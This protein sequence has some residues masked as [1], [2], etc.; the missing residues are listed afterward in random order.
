M[1]QHQTNSEIIHHRCSAN[2]L[3]HKGAAKSITALWVCPSKASHGPGGAAPRVESRT[4]RVG[5][6]AMNA[7]NAGS[8][9]ARTPIASRMACRFCCVLGH[10]SNRCSES[11]TGTPHGHW[12]ECRG[13]HLRSCVADCICP[14]RNLRITFLCDRFVIAWR[15]EASSYARMPDL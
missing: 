9:L 11:C 15:C 14:V 13:C 5:C 12:T 2:S 10:S 4:E 3:A 6:L 1:V 7:F 8:W